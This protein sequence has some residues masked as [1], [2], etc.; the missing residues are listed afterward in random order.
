MLESILLSIKK[1]IGID[2]E[3]TAFDKDLILLINAQFSVLYQVGVGESGFTITGE[4]ETWAD[5]L[6]DFS[7]LEMI[8]TYIAIRVK[9]IF[10][11]PTTSFVADALKAKAD[12]Y[13]WRIN[14]AVDPASDNLLRS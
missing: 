3:D 6:S 8:K 10:D 12:E 11:P 9:L 13:E 4:N 7:N 14:V 2:E 1:L 5:Y